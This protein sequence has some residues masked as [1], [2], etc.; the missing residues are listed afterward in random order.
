MG[1]DDVLVGWQLSIQALKDKLAAPAPGVPM[2]SRGLPL[3]AKPGVAVET[4]GRVLGAHLL[5]AGGVAQGYRGAAWGH[6]LARSSSA[7]CS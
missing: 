2:G 6:V 3:A 4:A 7:R 5:K 1:K